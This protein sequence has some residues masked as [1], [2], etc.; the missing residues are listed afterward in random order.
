MKTRDLVV[1]LAVVCLTFCLHIVAWAQLDPSLVLYFDFEDGQGDTVEDRSNYGSEGTIQG[2]AKWVDGKFGKGLELDGTS[3]VLVPDRD[4]FKITDEITLACWANFEAVDGQYNFL[5]CRFDWAGGD[6]RCYEM[7]LQAG[8]PNIVTSPDGGGGNTPA[9]ARDPVDV[10][11][12]YHLA[13]IFDGSELKIY[14]NGEEAGSAEPRGGKIF[15][16]EASI[17][18]GDNNS[19]LAPDFRFVGAIDEVAIYNRALSQSEIKQKMTS[20]HT[21]AV[22]SERKLAVAWGDVKAQY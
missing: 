11:E 1:S 20:G 16:G 19:G 8:V 22:K 12:W 6:N 7:Y 21:A 13:G 9:A 10:G 4:E 3:F 18:I 5:V 17:T 14:V 2:D 15:D